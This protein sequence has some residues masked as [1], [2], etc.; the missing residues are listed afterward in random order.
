[1]ILDKMDRLNE[2]HLLTE[3][4]RP[5][6]GARG[7]VREELADPG[8]QSGR[9]V[10]REVPLACEANDRELFSQLLLI[11]RGEVGV[12]GLREAK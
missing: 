12:Q 9:G 11:C 1:M 6:V 5:G 3:F 8:I 4:K 2:P 7:E 10:R